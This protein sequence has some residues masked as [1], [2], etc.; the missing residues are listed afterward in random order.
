MDVS[1][2][3]LASAALP[4]GRVLDTHWT[5]GWVGPR[6]GLVAVEYRIIS[7]FSWESN[8]G[9]GACSPS[10]YRLTYPGF[11][12]ANERNERVLIL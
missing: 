10:L 12:H 4:Q 8:P 3:L 7:S 5:G 6:A 1:N 9:L 2:Q 11:P